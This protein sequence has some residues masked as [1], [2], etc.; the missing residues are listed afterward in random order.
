MLFR[1]LHHGPDIILLTEGDAWAFS[2]GQSLPLQRGDVVFVPADVPYTLRSS[3]PTR[4][5][6]A[7]VPLGI[8]GE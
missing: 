2:R 4:L 5:F 1:S 8:P 3:R 6:K 7:T